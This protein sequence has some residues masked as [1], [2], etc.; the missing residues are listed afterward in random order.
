ME[1]ISL[2]LENLSRHIRVSQLLNIILEFQTDFSCMGNEIPAALTG[3]QEFEST[4]SF[5]SGNDM[6]VALSI[7]RIS[8]PS[9]TITLI[10]SI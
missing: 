6:L 4:N 2:R 8:V 5:V 9:I 10:R 3:T 7:I 1:K